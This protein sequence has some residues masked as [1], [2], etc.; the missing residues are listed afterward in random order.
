MGIN[1]FSQTFKSGFCSR[2]DEK[3]FKIYKCGEERSGGL[4]HDGHLA[5]SGIPLGL[6]A[7][8]P[9]HEGH[10]HEGGTLDEDGGGVEAHWLAVDPGGNG[11]ELYGDGGVF[12]VKVA[13][14]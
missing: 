11:V 6:G 8:V 2:P 10:G 13:R 5:S 4:R 14:L 12:L 1:F 3:K 7:K 9:G